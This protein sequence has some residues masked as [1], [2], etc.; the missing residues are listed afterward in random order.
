MSSSRD[1][2]T[3]C[4]GYLFL[5]SISI[6]FVTVVSNITL[7]IV[8]GKVSNA[9]NVLSVGQTF[10]CAGDPQYIEGKYYA[11]VEVQRNSKKSVFSA[12]FEERPPQQGVVA[13]SNKGR[14]VFLPVEE[15]AITKPPEK[16]EK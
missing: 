6:L 8:R 2:S 3:G 11:F 14:I 15:S 4:F 12:K 10:T 13:K 7:E 16:E 5:I 1:V 9:E